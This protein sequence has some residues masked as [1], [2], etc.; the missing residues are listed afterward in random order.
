MIIA[1]DKNASDGKF[2]WMEGDPATGGGGKGY[3]E[4]IINIPA[5]GHLRAVG[6]GHCLGWQQRF[7][8]GNL[9]TR[10]S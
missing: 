5:A 10:G 1:D 7:V 2:I 8:L 3:A 9:A 6:S 4:F